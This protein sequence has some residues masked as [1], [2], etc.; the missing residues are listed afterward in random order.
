[1]ARNGGDCGY[2]A[3]FQ[4]ADMN[5]SRA[6]LRDLGV[7]MVLDFEFDDIRCTQVHPADLGAAIVSFDQPVPASSWAWGGPAWTDEVRTQVV[8]GLAGIRLASLDPEAL[9][10]RWS[11]ALPSSRK[12]TAARSRGDGS[13]CVGPVGETGGPGWSHRSPGGDGVETSFE[14]PHRVPYR[15]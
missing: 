10:S 14:A 9:L 6:H 5:A 3:I 11:M 13:S 8:T 7:R 1:M 15:R 2:M 4:V 12:A